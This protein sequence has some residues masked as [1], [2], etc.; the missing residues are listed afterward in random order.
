MFNHKFRYLFILGLTAYSFFNTWFSGVFDVYQ[1]SFSEQFVLLGL[2]FITFLIWE[3]NRLLMLFTSRLSITRIHPLL[4]QFLLSLVVTGIICFSVVYLVGEQWMHASKIQYN[5][6]LRLSLL[7]GYRINLFL[8]SIN[9]T[10]YFFTQ[11][12]TKKME[13]DELRRAQMQAELQSIKSQINPHFLFNNLNV[14]SSLVLTG[15]EDANQFIEEFAEVYRYIL[16]FH[17]KDLVDLRSEIDFS[18]HYLFLLQRRFP[19][20]LEIINDIPESYFDY[21]MVPVALQ[22]LIENATKHNIISENKPLKI[23]IKVLDN[24]TRLI[25]K[26]NLQKKIVHE[27]SEHI[28]LKNIDERFLLVTGRGIKVIEESSFFSVE[29]PLIQIPTHELINN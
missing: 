29:V 19:G 12:R 18:K 11:Y 22:M 16:K 17:S 3:S 21:Y 25:I 7:Y 10:L 9:T 5:V 20:G 24:P 14:L 13:A 4:L 15:N 28:G 2:F 27:Q 26:N 8:Y 1:V 23:E 6:A